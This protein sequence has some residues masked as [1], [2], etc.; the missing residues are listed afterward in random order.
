[1]ATTYI[2]LREV[3]T[4]PSR[5]NGANPVYHVVAGVEAANAAQARVLAAKQ[6]P[7]VEVDA[8]V[9]LIAVPQRN[10]TTGRGTLKAETQRRIRSA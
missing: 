6:I 8:G 2:V 10:W 4:V 5:E 7:D 3:D 1:M 9:T